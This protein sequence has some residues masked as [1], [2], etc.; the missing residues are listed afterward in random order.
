MSICF[1][2]TSSLIP[3]VFP[4]YFALKFGALH[5]KKMRKKDSLIEKTENEKKKMIASYL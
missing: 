5:Q 4:F 3:E 1:V 2:S